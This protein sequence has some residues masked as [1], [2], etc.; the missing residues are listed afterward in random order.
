MPIITV[1]IPTYNR[2]HYLL[3]AVHSV[4]CQATNDIE[5]LII[6]DGSTDNSRQLIENISNKEPVRYLW[7][8]NG[9]DASARNFGIQHAKGEYITFLDS[10]DLLVENSISRQ[11]SVLRSNP[12]IGLVHADFEKFT[13][14]DQSLGRRDTSWFIG[15]VYPQILSYWK[16]IIAI[17]TVMIP[18]RVFKEVGVFNTSLRLGSDQ[19][20]WFRIARKY[21]FAHI[22]DVLAK[23]RVHDGNISGNRINEAV[24]FQQLLNIA[25]ENDTALSIDFR[26]YCFGQMYKTIGYNLLTDYGSSFMPEA[27]RRFE[28]AIKSNP[29]AWKAYTGWLLSYLPLGIR[30]ILGNCWRRKNYPVNQKS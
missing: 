23:V 29:K 22:P 3:Q 15:N 8:Q 5:I 4:L 30:R 16:S 18:A 9:G 19:D 21:P 17:D 11:L 7:K 10:D 27:R 28:M 1:I 12:D 14:N 20:M 25:F 24:I 2:E 13:E 6:D 26:K